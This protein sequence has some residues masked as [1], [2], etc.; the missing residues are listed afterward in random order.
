TDNN[1]WTALHEAAM[2]GH[3]TCVKLLLDYNPKQTD[4]ILHKD[5]Q[6]DI[7]KRGAENGMTSLHDA[8]ASNMVETVILLLEYGGDRL[9]KIKTEEKESAFD[10]AVTEEMRQLLHSF[11][12][13]DGKIDK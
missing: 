4:E 11:Q 9:L 12:G 8:V 13:K 10:L 1:G 6:C 3:N 7:M 5:G 2:R